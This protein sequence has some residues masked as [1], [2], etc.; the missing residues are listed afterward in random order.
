M[1]GAIKKTVCIPVI[2]TVSNV[3]TIE[4]TGA[5]TRIVL[6]VATTDLFK[7][8]AGADTDT[9]F[10]PASSTEAINKAAVG[11]ETVTW[12]STADRN[13]STNWL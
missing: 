3:S 11:A 12:F 13:V 2:R 8:G 4:A 5:V 9:V 7:A 10:A 1:V 6:A